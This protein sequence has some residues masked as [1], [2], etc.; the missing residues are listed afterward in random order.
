MRQFVRL[1]TVSLAALASLSC[2]KPHPPTPERE[3]IRESDSVPVAA[4]STRRPT[5]DALIRPFSLPVTSQAT[6]DELRRRVAATIWPEAE[7][8]ADTSQGVRLA[9]IQK[10]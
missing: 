10:L 5:V 1:A 9:T 4:P 3:I 7:T 2:V 8:V 6:L